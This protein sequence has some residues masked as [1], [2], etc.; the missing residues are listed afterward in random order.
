MPIRPLAWG[1][2]QPC[3]SMNKISQLIPETNLL[4]NL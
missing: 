2:N 4:L 1:V 3:N